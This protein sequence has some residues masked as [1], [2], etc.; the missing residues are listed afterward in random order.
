MDRGSG[1]ALALFAV[2]NDQGDEWHIAQVNVLA[3]KNVAFNIF[4]EGIIGRSAAG[5]SFA[6]DIALDDYMLKE[7]E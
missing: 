2:S 7:R 4:F 3:I 5:S 6:G 1:D